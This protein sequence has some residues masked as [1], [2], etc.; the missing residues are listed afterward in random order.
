MSK[1][2]EW[3][4][5]V[6]HG[7]SRRKIAEAIKFPQS[8]FNRKVGK[9]KIE[10]DAVIAVARAFKVSPVEALVKT[11]YLTSEEAVG[12]SSRE[13]ARMIGDKD[14]VREMALRIEENEGAWAGTFDEVV[15]SA[16]SADDAQPPP[17]VDPITLEVI[18]SANPEIDN[19]D[20]G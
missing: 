15:E 9:G 16:E 17:V 10:A 14:L 3:L 1:H 11:G 8:T 19:R 5:A 4:T 6:T 13:L 2:D 20:H 12:M 18:N 7:A